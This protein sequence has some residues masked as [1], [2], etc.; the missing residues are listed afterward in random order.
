MKKTFNFFNVSLR[1]IRGILSHFV[2]SFTK[3]SV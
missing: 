2:I 3:N 1:H